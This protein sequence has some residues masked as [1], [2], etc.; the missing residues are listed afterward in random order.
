MD[1]GGFELERCDGEKKKEREKG[2]SLCVC[3]SRFCRNLNLSSFS[4]CYFERR[5]KKQNYNG[6]YECEEKSIQK[7]EEKRFRC[8]KNM[9]LIF[10]RVL[11]N[12]CD[13]L[14]TRSIARL[15]TQI[16]TGLVLSFLCTLE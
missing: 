5:R 16:L 1:W 13:K 8:V 4:A 12:K 2:P 3:I 7:K 14:L 11:S 15:T 9:I 6:A 10:S